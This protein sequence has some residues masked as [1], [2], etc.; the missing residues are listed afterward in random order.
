MAKRIFL[1]WRPP[2]VSIE[3]FG[4]RLLTEQVPDLLP[5][6]PSVLQ[7]NIADVEPD[8]EELARGDGALLAGLISVELAR[9]GAEAEYARVLDPTGGYVAGYAVA[10]NVARGYDRRWWPDGEATPGAKQVTLL[11]RREDVSQEEFLRHWTEV[12][13]P[14][15]LEIH[16]AWGYVRNVVE[17][18]VT[19]NAPPYDGV[20]ELSVREKEDVTDPMRFFGCEEN[21]EVVLDDLKQWVDFEAMA[22]YSMT[23][24]I[25]KSGGG[26][27][28]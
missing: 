24:I 22:F 27:L 13:T 7:V 19:A 5:L 2:D 1:L 28:A 21:I 16:P 9:A 26:M 23:E 3:T 12:H 10:E 6:E 15:A 18:P 4:C 17:G 25:V 8:E 11:R 20:I 14:L